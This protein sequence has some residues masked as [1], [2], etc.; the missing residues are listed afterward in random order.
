M[1]RRLPA[2]V[3]AVVVV[4]CGSH[5]PT[6]PSSTAP[7]TVPSADPVARVQVK[8]D[9]GTPRDVLASTSEVV[10]DASASTGSG[11]LTFAIDFGDGTSATDATARHTYASAGTFT[12]VATVTDAQGRKATESS[13]IAV[14]AVTGRWF[15]AEYVKR[16]NR[17]EVRQLSIDAQDGLTVRGS[18]RTTGNADRSFTGTLTA[19]RTIQIALS[20]GAGLLGLLPDRL[21]DAT[22][23]WTLVARGDSVDGETEG[24]VAH[25]MN[26]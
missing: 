16:S 8:V 17:V 11:T 10:V 20:G 19:P 12:I 23:A 1:R 2:P 22:T 21:N 7:G 6:S 25:C 18:Y 9:D 4:A 3:L 24:L 5:P 15:Q 13:A 26:R 14:K